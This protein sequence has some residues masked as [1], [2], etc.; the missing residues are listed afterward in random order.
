MLPAVPR[1]V[2]DAGNA[3]G[4]AAAWEVRSSLDFTDEVRIGNS[5][6]SEEGGVSEFAADG[7]PGFMPV[8]KVSDCSS[9][10]QFQQVSADRPFNSPQRRQ[11]AR[12]P[13]C[14]SEEED[15]R[16][17]DWEKGAETDAGDP[18]CLGSK[19]GTNSGVGS[20]A[21]LPSLEV[22]FAPWPDTNLRTGFIV[23]ES[24]S[25]TARMI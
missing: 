23:E 21:P 10:S 25:G 17:D 6:S 24:F 15:E 7:G 20:P 18:A 12:C 22:A 14:N 1:R 13:V 19:P 3:L 11:R 4:I 8:G 2:E 9:A 5:G 16:D